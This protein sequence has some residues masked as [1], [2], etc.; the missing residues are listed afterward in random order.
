MLHHL[1]VSNTYRLY[2]IDDDPREKEDL[3]AAQPAEL[4]A[5]RRDYASYVAGLVEVPAAG[6]H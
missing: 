4:R 3:A 1:I 2:D 5:I 6:E